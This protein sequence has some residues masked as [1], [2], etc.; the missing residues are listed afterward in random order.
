MDSGFAVLQ[1]I[2]GGFLFTIFEK[3][4]PAA[5]NAMEKEI[6]QFAENKWVSSEI[7]QYF[8]KQVLS[9]FL[10]FLHIQDTSD[11]TTA[12]KASCSEDVTKKEMWQFE[13]MQVSSEMGIQ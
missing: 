5:I 2:A 8:F 6:W 11:S 12:V 1:S 7:V 10:L 13:N 3:K 9:M 4:K